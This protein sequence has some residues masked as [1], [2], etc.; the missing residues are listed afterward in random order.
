VCARYL[1]IY[2]KMFFHPVL[3]DATDTWEEWQ[4][5][6]TCREQH[7]WNNKHSVMASEHENQ[8]LEKINTYMQLTCFDSYMGHCQFKR[9]PFTKI[10]LSW[11]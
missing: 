11:E 9:K 2:Q 7:D 10:G 5:S 1:I 8:P 6:C 3:E 4:W